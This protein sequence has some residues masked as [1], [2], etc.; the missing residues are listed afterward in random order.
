MSA[1]RWIFTERRCRVSTNRQS[2]NLEAGAETMPCTQNVTESRLITSRRDKFD[3]L[4]RSRASR[5]W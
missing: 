4:T 1:A 5:S 2:K 3:S